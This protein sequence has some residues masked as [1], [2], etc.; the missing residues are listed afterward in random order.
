MGHLVEI[1]VPCFNEERALPMLNNKYQ[2][3]KKDDP[4][5]DY[6]L[7]IIDNGS[8]DLTLQ[9]AVTMA[10]LDKSIRVI[11]L[12]RNFGKE[13]SLTAGLNNS[14]GNLVIPMDADL[15][16]P[17]ELIPT[18]IKR[19]DIG[20]ADIILG[21]RKS[22][23]EDR[24]H[25]KIFSHIY[26]R[27]FSLISD[28]NLPNNVG[29][30]RLMNRKVDDAFNSIPESEKFVRGI[31]AFM[32]IRL[33][34]VEYERPARKGSNSRFSFGN[35]LNFGISGI[36]S[37]STKPLRIATY[38]GFVGSLL[39]MLYGITIIILQ[40]TG[41]ISLTGYAS[42]IASILILGSL[43]LLTIGI[44]GEYVGKTLLE[45]KRRPVY[46]IEQRWP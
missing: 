14:I 29:E 21:K 37:F 8:S 24:L 31:F 35:L 43:Q 13:A 34:T 20:D 39:S 15:Q 42:V 44:L 26:S 3:L 12:S 27:F 36:V 38:L 22:R 5:N 18:L 25:R 30:F 6:H 28:I 17:I 19:Y 41:K 33:A 40:L 23:N 16:D 46:F 2:Q 32:G 10:S 1:V 9:A 11:R 4:I 45:S 7:L